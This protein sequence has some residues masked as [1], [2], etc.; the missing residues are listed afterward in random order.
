MS[1][2]DNYT[3]A[4]PACAESISVNAS[5]RAALLDQ[6]CVI[7]GTRVSRDAFTSE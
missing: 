6:G 4:C 7:C 5:M 2:T 3:F 1:T